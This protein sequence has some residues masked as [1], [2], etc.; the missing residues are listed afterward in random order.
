MVEI[1]FYI[2]RIETNLT[3]TSSALMNEATFFISQFEK[4]SKFAALIFSVAGSRTA[5]HLVNTLTE[6]GPR[7]FYSFAI[8]YVATRT[9]HLFP[10][11]FQ[12]G[13][14]QSWIDCFHK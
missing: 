11:K 6:T 1:L 10:E 9:R 13:L 3:V 5:S 2:D 8:T 7:W 4:W 14:N 12:T